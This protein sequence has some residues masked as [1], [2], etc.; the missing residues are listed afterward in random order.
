MPQELPHPAC[1]LQPDYV[2]AVEGPVQTKTDAIDCIIPDPSNACCII[3]MLHNILPPH[4]PTCNTPT[5]S[6]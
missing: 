2:L 5:T 4:S 1:Y 3:Q 6:L